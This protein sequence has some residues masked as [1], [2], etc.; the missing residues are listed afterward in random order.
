ME[1]FKYFGVHLDNKLD[2]RQNSVAIFEEE[3]EPAAPP[4]EM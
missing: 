2:W 1:V 3:T 4:G